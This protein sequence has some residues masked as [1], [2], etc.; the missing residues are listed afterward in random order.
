MRVPPA[1]SA[2]LLSPPATHPLL[3]KQANGS[4]AASELSILRLTGFCVTISDFDQQL[5]ACAP[6]STAISPFVSTSVTSVPSCGYFVTTVTAESSD[7]A[8][9]L[10]CGGE[11]HR[12]RRPY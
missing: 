7:R 3:A 8:R 10:S 9:T 11:Q 1:K 5:S 6:N 12:H 2:A 4:Y